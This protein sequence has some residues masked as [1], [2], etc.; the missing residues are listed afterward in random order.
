[1]GRLA[2][3]AAPLPLFIF[4]GWS[5]LITLK[6]Y[7]HETE[8]VKMG[9]GFFEGWPNPPTEEVHRRILGESY[10]ALVAIDT[11]KNEI[12][13]FVN[14]VSEG[15]LSAY[16]PLLEVLPA[17]RGRGIGTLLVKAMLE[18]LQDLYMVDLCC[19][20][21]LQSFYE[22]LGMTRSCG[23]ICRNYLAQGGKTT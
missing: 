21:R 18:E 20:Q 13:G 12:V 16:L 17:Y 7:S 14:A 6:R 19:D 22:R 8:T 10:L 2:A 4:G 9:R 15:V 11:D 3:R 5:S 23:M 1:M